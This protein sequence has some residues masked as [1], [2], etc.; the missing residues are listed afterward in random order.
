MDSNNKSNEKIDKDWENQTNKEKKDAL[1][2]NQPY[3]QPTFRIFLS[4]LSVQAMIALGKIENP[5][6]GKLEKN[7]SQT[8]F[9]I[10]TLEI[11]KVKTKNNLT[12]EEEDLLNEY[13][14]NLKTI[15]LEAT[16]KE[17]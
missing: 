11:I 5:I 17:E 3:H 8:H 4:S 12:N 6:T 14:L 16:K 7:Y 13:L 2:L 15:Y 10:E 9:L 1:D